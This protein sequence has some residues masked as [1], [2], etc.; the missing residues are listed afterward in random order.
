MSTAEATV[1][2]VRLQSERASTSL[3]LGLVTT[4][5]TLIVALPIA[6]LVFESTNAGAR[7]FWEVVS[8]PEAVAALKLTLWTSIAVALLNGVLGTITAWVLVRD[9]FRG[10]ALMNAII[11]LPF[12]LPT[13]VAG[14]TLLALYGQSSPVGLNL[15]YTR[16]GVCLAL[17][18]VTLPFVVRSVQPVLLTMEPDMEEAAR[19][20][21]AGPF[22]TF[23][24]VLLPTIAVTGWAAW[25]VRSTYA[26]WSKVDSGINMDAFE[27]AR[28]LLDRQGLREVRIEPTPGQLTDH[29]D[30]RGKVLRVNRDGAA[31]PGTGSN[32]VH[33]F[34]T[35]FPARRRIPDATS[36]RSPRK[37]VGG[38]ITSRRRIG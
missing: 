17:A 19:C 1:K 6:A 18:F 30:P 8:S 31:A 7:G 27:F 4:Y 16:A 2:G 12:A 36:S 35:Q 28:Q 29:Y 23:R 14:I 5:L 10:K 13:I 33:P 21:G 38:S 26:K 9:S 20:L 25:R 37:F 32:A 34:L 24:R 15:A 11:D 3:S 22:T